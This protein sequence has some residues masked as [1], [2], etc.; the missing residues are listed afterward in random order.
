VQVFSNEKLTTELLDRLGHHA[1]IPV[2][3]TI[4]ADQSG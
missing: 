3:R 1:H 2:T 4:T